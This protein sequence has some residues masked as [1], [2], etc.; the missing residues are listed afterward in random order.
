MCGV[1]NKT[2]KSKE[3][4][5]ANHVLQLRDYT[6]KHYFSLTVTVFKNSRVMNTCPVYTCN[7][8]EKIY[9]E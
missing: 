9:V 4:K 5:T 2:S 8:H 3:I 6:N 1:P 7:S